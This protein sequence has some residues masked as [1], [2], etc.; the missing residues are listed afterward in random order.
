MTFA[1]ALQQMVHGE[2]ACRSGWNGIGMYVRKLSG[3]LADGSEV[4]QFYIGMMG[5]SEMDPWM[6]SNKD[7]FATDW[8]VL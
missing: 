2:S 1:Q 3:T 4:T 7:L 6:P 8:I 5:R